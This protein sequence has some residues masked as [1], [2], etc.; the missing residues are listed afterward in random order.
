MRTMIIVLACTVTAFGYGYWDI[1]G[2]GGRVLSLSPVSAGMCGAVVPDGSSAFSLFT[3]PSALAGSDKVIVSLSG[4]GTGW[5]EEIIY[6]YT[7]TEPS[8]FNLGS[9]SPRGAFAVTMP[10]GGG[11]TA[12]AGIATVSQYQMKAMVQEYHE[13]TSYKRELWKTLT[14]DATGD[15]N[16]ALVSIAGT[17]GPVNIGV[18]PGIRFGGGESTTYSNRVSGQDSTFTESWDVTGF[19]LRAGASMAIGYTVLYSTHT[20]GDSRYLSF[21]NIGASA[22]FPFMKGGYLG[23]ELGVFDGDNLNVTA[24]TRLPGVIEGSN[25]YLGLNGYRPDAALKTGIGLSIGGDYS[26][27]NYRVSAAYHFHSRYRDGTAVPVQYINYVY[28]AGDTV[29]A[30]IERTF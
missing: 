15:L 27:R 8:R 17:V 18:S 16:E 21:S 3:N 26:F 1:F 11:F 10:L 25:M 7:C 24:F 29:T 19:A 23:A 20:S 12:G 2:V 30:G 13:V 28:D 22:S 4:W 5:R 9:M 14:T 6:H